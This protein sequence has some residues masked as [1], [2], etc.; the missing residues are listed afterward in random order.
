V[1]FVVKDIGS[2]RDKSAE[3][4]DGVERRLRPWKGKHQEL[5]GIHFLLKEKQALLSVIYVLKR[6]SPVKLDSTPQAFK[7]AGLFCYTVPCSALK[8]QSDELQLPSVLFLDI[9]LISV[10]YHRL[11]EYLAT[12]RN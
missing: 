3:E 6:Y 9:F 11:L 10:R 5:C 2:C 4:R 12:T 1:K 7:T 8:K